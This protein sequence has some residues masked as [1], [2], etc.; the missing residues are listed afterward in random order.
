M[1]AEGGMGII[2]CT[3]FVDANVRSHNNWIPAIRLEGYFVDGD[4]VHNIETGENFST[5]QAAIEDNDTQD[6]HTIK[7]DAG[8][9]VE[10]VVVKKR[11]TLRGIG[12]P[13]VD[14]NGSGSAITVSADGCVVDGFNITSAGSGSEF[15]FIAGIRVTSDDN[16]LSNNTAMN[17]DYGIVLRYY[18][19]DNTL[20]NNIAS[21]NKYDGIHIDFSSNNYI[22]DNTVSDNEVGIKIMRASNY[23]KITN[24]NLSSNKEWGIRQFVPELAPWL[25]F[26][27]DYLT[28]ANNNVSNNGNGIYLSDSGSNT[29]TGNVVYSNT[30]YGIRLFGSLGNGLRKNVLYDNKYNFGVVGSGTNWNQDIDTTNTVDG[31]PIYYL[32]GKSDITLDESTNAG[33]VALISCNKI[34]VKNLNLRNNGQGILLVGTHN[35]ILH[36]NTVMNNE[37]GIF[38]DFNSRSNF[39]YHNI[40]MNNSNQ[41]YDFGGY[42]T[43]DKGP[44]IGGNYWSDHQCTGNPSDGGQPYNIPGYHGSG[45][46]DCHPFEDQWGWKKE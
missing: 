30:G 16:T 4:G 19:S 32:I 3:S 35:S 37:Y 33:Y 38:M 15:D 29:V 27:S 1:A 42:S 44:A 17:N 23:N 8:T 9:Y 11:L 12:M 26:S 25:G 31:K 45:A 7:V 10:N 36:N 20:T 39:V 24:N 28:I 46:Q 34:T 22:I 18:V 5:I 13:T 6:G 2:N 41:A 40:F 21:A 14:A 43:W